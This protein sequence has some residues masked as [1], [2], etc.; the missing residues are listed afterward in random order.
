MSTVRPCAA[1]LVRGV[2]ERDVL[3]H[4]GAGQLH[5]PA[6]PFAP[7]VPLVG[8][9]VG[10]VAVDDR[11]DG[12]PAVGAGGE[13]AV[14]L[15]GD[16]GG[17]VALE[18]AQVPGQRAGLDQVAD[19]GDG[20]APL[21]QR[22]ALPQRRRRAPGRG[23]AGPARRAAGGDAGGGGVGADHQQRLAAVEGVGQPRPGGGGLGLLGGAAVDEPAVLGVLGEHGRVAV[24]QPQRRGAFPVVGGSGGPRRAGST[25]PCSATSASAPPGPIAVSWRGSPT[26]SSLAPAAA[27]RCRIGEQVGGLG[28]ACLVE[29]DQV[30]GAQP[31]RARRRRLRVGARAG[32][33]R[34]GSGWRARRRRSSCAAPSPA[35]TSAAFW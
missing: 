5:R 25:M 30:S 29:H 16:R 22:L 34:A 33:G 7:H 28:G 13:H 27:Q 17:G 23:R 12:Q 8:V 3:A 1:S 20:A 10:R 9:G 18:P 19:P 32:R 21:G 2:A 26:S 14:G 31:P 24:A 4:V 15:A 11:G 6:E 35:R